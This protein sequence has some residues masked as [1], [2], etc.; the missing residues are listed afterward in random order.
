LLG[1]NFLEP[2]DLRLH[3]F[4]APN[5][6]ALEAAKFCAPGVKSFLADPMAAA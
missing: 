3:L 5:L 2:R 6:G 1:H 4:H